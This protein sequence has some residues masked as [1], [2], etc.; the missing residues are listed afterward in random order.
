MSEK[1]IYFGEALALYLYSHGVLYRG[2]ER[3][4]RELSE[5]TMSH[6]QGCGRLLGHSRALKYL[7]GGSS[8][9]IWRLVDSLEPARVEV[10][11]PNIVFHNRKCISNSA[12]PRFLTGLWLRIPLRLS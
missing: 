6:W 4:L 10:M 1:M 11:S 2:R 3:N 9:V 5:T 12:N 7:W 8:E